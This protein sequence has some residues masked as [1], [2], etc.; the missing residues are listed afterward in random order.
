MS[1]TPHQQLEALLSGDADETD[2]RLLVDQLE[3]DSSLSKNVAAEL[4]FLGMLRAASLPQEQLQDRASKIQR[5][6]TAATGNAAHNRTNA[7]MARIA[8][9]KQPPRLQQRIMLFAA[10]AAVAVFGF[11]IAPS[12]NPGVGIV[13]SAGVG[14]DLVRG[15][16]VVPLKD[17]L[18]LQHGDRIVGGGNTESFAIATNDGTRLLANGS[19]DLSCR[20]DGQGRHFLLES[21]DLELDVTPQPPGHPLI[22][23]TPLARATIV[24]TV[25]RVQ[26]APEQ[27]RLDV[28]EGAVVFANL[29]EDR[30]VVEANQ[31]AVAKRG[32]TKITGSLTAIAPPGEVRKAHDR[33]QSW[34]QEFSKDP[35]LVLHYTFDSDTSDRGWL[36]NEAPAPE[37]PIFP[38]NL[39]GRIY[40]CTWS[41]GRFP[42]LKDALLFQQ[43][44]YV[45]C[46]RDPAIPT[47]EPFTCMAWF[48]PLFLHKGW[49]GV[50]TTGINGWGIQLNKETN[51]VNFYY[52]TE[53]AHENARTIDTVNMNEWHF[54]VGIFDGTYS[55]IYLNGKFMSKYRVTGTKSPFHEPLMIGGNFEKQPVRPFQGWVDEVAV[56]RRVMTPEE[57][58]EAYEAGKPE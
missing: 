19:V 58:A 36:L 33:W 18:R 15:D 24:G 30:R 39:D 2:L 37:D 34:R 51:S 10:V 43:D 11:F 45:N 16:K 12:P 29:H 40:N 55:R 4:R 41:D 27:T 22:V 8:E 35:A 38:R 52:K 53:V 50:V 20:R 44:A 31:F 28:S 21:G 54:A 7:V 56:L 9:R 25:L 49:T 32:E 3:P 14:Y 48:K 17:N 1:D 6:T 26:A 5:V 13:S 47:G 46:G 57:I 23:I 42:G